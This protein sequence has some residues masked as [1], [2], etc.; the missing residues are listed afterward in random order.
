MNVFYEIIGYLGM[1]L[2]LCSFLM[3][4]IKWV[5]II[6]MCGAV[7]SMIYGILTFTIPTACLNGALLLING[8]FV[9]SYIMKNK[10]EKDNDKDKDESN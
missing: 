1:A 10:K 9:V 3:K 7:L 5:R 2:V 6:N 4:D 8:I